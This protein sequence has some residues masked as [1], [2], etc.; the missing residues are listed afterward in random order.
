MALLFISNLV[1]D[2]EFYWNPAFTRSGNNV[3]SGIADSLS[4]SEDTEL[5]SCQPIPSFPNG[6]FW[7]G[8]HHD[9]TKA[10]N[11]IYFLPILNLKIIKNLFWGLSCFLYIIKWRRRHKNENRKVLVYNIYTP[12]ISILYRICKLTDCKLYTILYDLGIPPKR[13]GL[14]KITMLGYKLSE[15]AAKKYVPKLDGRIVINEQI[16][17]YYASGKDY[18]LV[19]GGINEQVIQNLFPL[20]ESDKK[21]F[22][23]VCAGMLWD[24]NGTKLILDAMELVNDSKLKVIFAGRGNDVSIIKERANVDSRISYVGML[25]MEEL[26]KVYQNADVLMNLRIEEDIDFHFPSKLLEY[27]VTGK[28]VLST[29]VAHAERDYG[30]FMTILNDI[31]PDGLASKLNEILTMDKSTLFKIGVKSREFMLK[32]RTWDYRTKEIVNYLNAK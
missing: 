9:F 18:I 27:L 7:V 2:R 10:G 29:P 28:Y 20:K 11:K 5:I 8:A 6:K 21:D 12:P 24:Q 32:N 1:P 26:F 30:E 4:S 15:K 16:A 19:D 3:L 25:S 17:N 23:F 14:S 31:T 22:V 13:L